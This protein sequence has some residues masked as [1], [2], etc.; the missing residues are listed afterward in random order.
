M[1]EDEDAEATPSLEPIHIHHIGFAQEEIFQPGHHWVSGR[2]GIQ[3][4]NILKFYRPT[5]V[6]IEI[7]ELH[8]TSQCS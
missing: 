6:E 2:P 7:P 1:Q 4:S 8:R 5:F 3:A